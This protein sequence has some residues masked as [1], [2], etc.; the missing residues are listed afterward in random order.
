MP[1]RRC[2]LL[3]LL[4]IATPAFAADGVTIAVASNF[5]TT[6]AELAA[7]F[8][9][10][11]GITVRISSG[12]TGKLYAQIL[13]GAPFDAFLAADAER[14]MLLEQSGHAL[15]DSRFTYA[16]G[17]LVLWSRDAP[18]CLAVLADARAGRIALANPD[19]A[20]YGRAARE[21]LQNEGYWEA[22]SGRAVYGENI[23]QTLH[24]AATGNAVLGLVARSQLG[25][26]QLP[27]PGCTWEVP[28]AT[29]RGIEQ[30][31]VL[32]ARASANAGARQFLDF[33]RSA[34]AMDILD[35]HG[36]GVGP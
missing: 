6:A 13:N 26:P 17:A 32:L 31:A 15:P 18:D 11:T 20:P 12:S 28:A 16:T 35:R 21:F 22:V 34:D 23:A 33:L 8:T 36:Y 4:L 30:Q 7:R 3:W 1:S 5:A 2:G 10:D 14:P 19:T 24:F 29:H 9:A 27:R 25:A